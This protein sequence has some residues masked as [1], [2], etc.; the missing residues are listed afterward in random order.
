VD[1][2]LILYSATLQLS[3]AAWLMNSVDR[4]T[5]VHLRA[6]I[7]RNATENAV[8]SHKTTGVLAR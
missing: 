6:T 4:M 1:I 2:A 3:P 5:S 7:S 8:K